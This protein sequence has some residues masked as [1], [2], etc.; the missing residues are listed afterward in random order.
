MEIMEIIKDALVFPS[1]DLRTFFIFVLLTIFAGVFGTVGIL[2]YILGVLNAEFFLWG[3]LAAI[4]A[5]LIGWVMSGYSISVIKSGIELEDE[6]PEFVWW[7]N[8]ITGFNGF[9]VSIVYFIIPA[10]LVAIVGYMTNITGNIMAVATEISSQ[11][12]NVYT[13]ASA[14]IATDALSQAVAGLAVSLATTLTAAVVLFVIF[15]FLQTMAEARLAN[16]DSLCEAL[17]V[18][19]AAKDIGRIGVVKVIAVILLVIIVS[20]VINMV[21]SAIFSYVPILSILSV[22]VSPYLVL[23]AQRAVGLLYSDIA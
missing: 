2:L 8:F 16:T 17:N 6:V 18:F 13:G 22:F 5:M 20:A 9:I 1:T 12:V 11:A 19:E 23:F 7:D 15:S 10:F 21:L 3:G 14:S 4:V